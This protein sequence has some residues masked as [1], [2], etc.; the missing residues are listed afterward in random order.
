MGHNTSRRVSPPRQLV[1]QRLEQALTELQR[2]MGGLPPPAEADGVWTSIW[3][4]EAHHSTALEGNTLV[5][6][7]V[8]AL[9]A[10]GRA[11]GNKELSQYLEVTGYATAAQWVYGHALNA[12]GWAGKT[13]LTLAEVRHAHELAMGRYGGW[14][15]IPTL[16][17]ASARAASESTTSSPSPEGWCPRPGS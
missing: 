4:Q 9:L 3:Y 8:E 7:H 10:E 5:I 14:R 13:P 15:R 2:R 16:F 12:G 17:P 1:Y 11:V 6:R